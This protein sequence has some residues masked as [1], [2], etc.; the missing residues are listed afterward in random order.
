MIKR[1]AVIKEGDLEGDTI[2]DNMNLETER[3]PEFLLKWLN[4][5]GIQVDSLK[6]DLKEALEKVSANEEAT[7]Q[8]S[9]KDKDGYNNIYFNKII[10]EGDVSGS[11]GGG[12]GGDN[13]SDAP[14]FYNMKK[15]YEKENG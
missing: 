3:G 10:D 12:D 1:Y 5:M 9:V 8:C 4:L 11:D 6:K 14:D 13:K 2:Y 7:F 15:K